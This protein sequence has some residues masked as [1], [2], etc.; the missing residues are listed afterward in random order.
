MGCGCKKKKK[1]TQPAPEP[2]Q[3]PLMAMLT[4]PDAEKPVQAR[5]VNCVGLLRTNSGQY[6]TMNTGE[7]YEVTHG[8]VMRWRLQGWA[9][10]VQ[11]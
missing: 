8:D 1:I 4:N 6:V 9:I 11:K 10:E 7:F 2:Q 5:C 3:A